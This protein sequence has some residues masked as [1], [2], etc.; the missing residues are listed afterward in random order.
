MAEIILSMKM[1]RK[2]RNEIVYSQGDEAS[3][4]MYCWTDN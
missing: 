2:P 4:C 3:A 1:V